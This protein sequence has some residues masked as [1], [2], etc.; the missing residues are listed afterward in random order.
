[1]IEAESQAVLNTL[2]K[3]HFQDAWKI[4]QKRWERCIRAEE[5]TSKVM[6]AS[7][8]KIS[9]WPDDSTSPWNYGW[10][11]VTITILD[12]IHRPVFYLK[13]RLGDWILSPSSGWKYSVGSNRSSLCLRTESRLW[14]VEY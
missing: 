4:L 8:P 9:F 10:L 14:N 11:F 13:Q 3:H 12:I 6:V 5:D 1:V 7:R 2:T